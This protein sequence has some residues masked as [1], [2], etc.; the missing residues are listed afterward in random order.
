MSELIKTFENLIKDDD[1]YVFD[2]VITRKVRTSVESLIREKTKLEE[3]IIIID[4]LL[5]EIN[6]L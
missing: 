1:M 3:R 2:E 4:I 6:K 5:E